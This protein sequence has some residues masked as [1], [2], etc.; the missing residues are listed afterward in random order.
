MIGREGVS[1]TSPLLLGEHG[2]EM[3]GV[4]RQM[5]VF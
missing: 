5:D 2:S 3:A 4:A 1:G